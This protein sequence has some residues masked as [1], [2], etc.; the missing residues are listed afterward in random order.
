MTSIPTEP[1]ARWAGRNSAK[2]ALRAEIWSAL[3]RDGLNVGPAWSRIPNWVGADEAAKRLSD[4][5]I[6][7][8]AR[9]VKC[10]PDPPQIPVRLRALY[11]GKRVYMP[12][13][14]FEDGGLPWAL[15]DPDKLAAAKVDFELAATSQGALRHGELCGFED[16]ARL[17]LVVCGSVAATRAGARTGK[18]G[19]F[20]DLELGLFRELGTIGPDTPVVTTVH[21]SMLVDNDR[22]PMLPHDSVLDWIVTERE[23]IETRTSHPQPKGVVWDA[24]EEDQFRDI[25]FLRDLQ[26]KILRRR[27]SGASPAG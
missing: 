24:V 25:W 1:K 26:A 14:Q 20:A 27:A 21:S 4:L 17:D 16:V 2:D 5:P 19:G 13:P 10:N 23:V 15:L 18:G 7:R 12:V 22:I 11:A 9:V 6:W 3:E 8:H